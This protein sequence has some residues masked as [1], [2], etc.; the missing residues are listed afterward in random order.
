MYMYQL[1]T[2]KEYNVW[3]FKKMWNWAWIEL[4]DPDLSN[5]D[6]DFMNYKARFPPF[7]AGIFMDET[8]CEGFDKQVHKRLYS[9]EV[10]HF[11]PENKPSQKESSLPTIIFSILNDGTYTKLV[12]VAAGWSTHYKMPG[13]WLKLVA[14]IL[15]AFQVSWKSRFQ[16]NRKKL[17]KVMSMISSLFITFRFNVERLLTSSTNDDFFLFSRIPTNIAN[18]WLWRQGLVMTRRQKAQFAQ[19]AQRAKTSKKRLTGDGMVTD[20]QRPVDPVYVVDRAYTN[21]LYGNYNE[22]WYGSLL[23]N[24]YNGIKQRFWTLLRWWQ[25]DSAVFDVKFG[26]VGVDQ[27]LKM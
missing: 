5:V 13:S 25:H 16:R 4:R 2:S 3:L 22:P 20:E 17:G 11:A 14:D 27:G 6:I 18:W 9:L 8:P 1:L 24:Q 10:Q 15:I 21:E 23:I 7:S 19:R 26:I 12:G